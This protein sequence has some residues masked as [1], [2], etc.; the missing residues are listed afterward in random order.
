MNLKEPNSKLVR[1][2]LK[3]E[4]F[5]YE[6]IYKKGKQNTN[7][8]ALSRVKIN[9]PHK[10]VSQEL[11]NNTSTIHSA[12][13]NLDDGI[14]ISEKPLNE[15]NLQIILQINHTGSPATVENI[16][17]NRQRRIIRELHFNEGTM[18][19]IFKKYFPPNKQIAFTLTTTFFRSCNPHILNIFHKQKRFA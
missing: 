11:F 13:E 5:D 17:K 1:W 9:E 2:T 4:E 10:E 3:L 14:P 12:D 15:F 7:A 19:D 6:I 16:F 8:D 18:V